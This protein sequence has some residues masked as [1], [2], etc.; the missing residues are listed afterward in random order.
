MFHFA[1]GF[2]RAGEIVIDYVRHNSLK[3]GYGP[4]KGPPTL[5]RLVIDLAGKAVR[6]SA[7]GDFAT[8]FPR[9][10]DEFEATPSRFIYL[11][12]LTD[13][14]KLPNIP[15]AVFNTIVKA[16]AET[17]RTIRHDFGNAIG[18]EP[19]S[20]RAG[21]APRRTTAISPSLPTIRS[22]PAAGSSCSTRLM[23]TPIP[24]P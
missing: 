5:H 15:S 7:L 21:P 6:D 16:D 24:S 4:R 18:G 19:R 13:T 3:L 8:E 2:E 20:S 9:I 10:N 1:N 23:S 12:T 17:G 14:L 11:P 22:T